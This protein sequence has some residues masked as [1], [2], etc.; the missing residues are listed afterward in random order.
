[1]KTR[2]VPVL[3]VLLSACHHQQ[4]ASPQAA[5]PC[6]I[7]LAEADD[8]LRTRIQSAKDPLPFLEKLG[9]AYIAKARASFDPGYYKLA[10]Q[11]ALCMADKAPGNLDAALLRGH[12]LHSL[13]QFK[14]GETI[15]RELVAKR[16]LWFDYALLGDVLMEQGRLAEA[17]PA[18]QAMMDQKPGPEAYSRAAHLRWLKGDLTGAIEL[19][20]LAGTDPWMQTRLAFYEL[21]AGQT[22]VVFPADFP[23]ALLLRGKIT[24]DL[25]ALTRAA[26]ATKLP[27]YLW[28]LADEQRAAGKLTDAQA[29]EET[30][31]QRGALEDPRTY[32]LYLATRGE[33]VATAVRLAREELLNRQDVFTYDVLAWALHAA[34]QADEARTQMQRALAEGTVDARLALHAAV[35]L[36][37]PLPVQP[38]LLLPSE[39]KFL[40]VNPIAQAQRNPFRTNPNQP[41][42]MQ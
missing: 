23:P 17:V 26:Q 16:G 15:A 21:Q 13:H 19:M 10:E 35:I 4:P 8:Q 33:D 34:G 1:M 39:K 30:L 36:G 42:E 22:N 12:V 20:R 5:T 28:A 24:H 32:A 7:A 14:A 11:T 38:E 31:R 27:E 40:P 29:T 6:D 18:Y 3:A 2:L 37:Q 25:A 9:W 41:Q